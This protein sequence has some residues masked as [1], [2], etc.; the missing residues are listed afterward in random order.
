MTAIALSARVLL[1]IVCG[2]IVGSASP[3]VAMAFLV[4]LLALE[5]GQP[6]APRH[7][8]TPFFATGFLLGVIWFALSGLPSLLTVIGRWKGIA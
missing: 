6:N 7:P 1:M 4:I 3:L 2:A 5:Y 8:E